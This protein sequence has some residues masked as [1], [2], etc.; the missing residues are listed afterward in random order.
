MDKNGVRVQEHLFPGSAVASSKTSKVGIWMP[1]M[2]GDIRRDTMGHPPE[3][4]GM[5][6]NLMMAMWQ[7]NGQLSD[8]E[9]YLC[10]ISGASHDQWIR[11]RSELSN[12]FV[13]GYSLWTHNG[14][15]VQLAKA[16]QVSETKRIA[17]KKGNETRWSKDREAKKLTQ[18]LL[19]KITHDGSA[20]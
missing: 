13:P 19:E 5:Y 16:G 6:I 14:I 9:G 10:R 4:V 20:Y 8:D 7:N 3:F 1:V 18:T 12:L 2:I 15:R 11:Y 17:A